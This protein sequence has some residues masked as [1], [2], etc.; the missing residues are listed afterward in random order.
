MQG[1]RQKNFQGRCNG[2]KT[3][4]SKKDQKILLLSLFQGE[5]QRKKDRK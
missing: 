5:G 4:N 1:R 2:K 3:E